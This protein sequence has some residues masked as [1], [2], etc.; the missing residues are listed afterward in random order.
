MKLKSTVKKLLKIRQYISQSHYL[1]YLE[2]LAIDESA[3]LLECQHGTAM[4]GNI[5]YLLKEL[6][7]EEK[8]SHFKV[9]ISVNKKYKKDIMAILNSYSFDRYNVVIMNTDEY[10]QKI[11][12]CKYL[13]NDNTFLP[14]FIKRKE[15]V[16]LNT[17]H[18]TPLKTLGKKINND[19]HNI[20]NTMKNFI[21]SDYLLYPNEH[22]KDVMIEDYMLENLSQ[23]KVVL[24]GYPRNSIFFD[25]NSA[26][27]VRKKYN[28]TDK[29]VIAYMPTWRGTT[30][31]KNVDEQI[32]EILLYLHQIDCQLDEDCVIYV[33]FHPI[34]HAQVKFSQF[35][36]IKSFPSNIDT[37]EF[38]NVCDVLITDYSSVFFDYAISRKK[39]ILFTYDKEQYFEDRGV[40]IS[41]D[42]LPFPKVETVDA[43]MAEIKKVKNYDDD[44]FIKEFC[45][46]ENI[47]SSGKLLDLVL[48]GENHSLLISDI[49]NNGKENVLIY[50]GN[51]AK[52]GITSSLMN[53]L[54]NIDLDKRN[55]YVTFFSRRVYPYRDTIRMLPKQ[56]GFIPVTGKMNASLAEKQILKKYRA[57]KI[58]IDE[59]YPTLKKLY[60]YEILRKFGTDNFNHVIHFTG[61]EF[62]MQLLFSF[63]EKARKSIFVHSNMVEE[64]RV[65]KNQHL[66][67]LKYAYT[68]Y[69][70]V[71]IIT[72]DMFAPTKEI[73]G[74]DK[75][76]YVVSNTFDYRN[77]I[78]KSK[79]EIAFDENTKC[80]ITEQELK[81]IMND[82]H[83]IKFINIGRFS[84]E[85]GHKRLILAFD[86]IYNKHS[87][88]YLIIIGGHGV[89]YENTIEM[90]N[91]LKSKTH[92]ILIKS[93][94]NPFSILKKCQCFAFSSFYEGLGLVVLEADVLGVSVFSTNIPG[95]R[96]FI[97]KYGGVLVDNSQ[98]GLEEGFEKYYQG[99][100]HPMGI[101]Y[102]K[103]NA[104]AVEEFENLLS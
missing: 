15:Q 29:K 89:E 42:D 92:I 67:T 97:T 28:L 77:V 33:N 39:I 22:T 86:Q 24:G 96:G 3:I 104:E 31:N 78:E 47:N 48:F 90:I 37:Y 93:M 57:D 85:K 99:Q 75:N 13:I 53:L 30:A 11:A 12:T 74:S 4:N 54:Q 65:R 69:D 16:Y 45:S 102:D 73:A 103:Y 62:K 76:F 68:H 34:I 63:F 58:S 25:K 43:L 6:C 55:Y 35:Q 59:T 32:E 2:S 88:A 36:K 61:Y 41:I 18:G 71:A 66:N 7:T 101:D 64:L 72:K 94:S 46:Y 81:E 8:Y 38:L 79:Q 23:A 17:W 84:P 21:V 83:K 9:Y 98:F 10:Y 52:N 87:D 51:F 100:I 95:P 19:F 14:F 44:D 26:Q 1:H 60:S 27:N 82:D 56:V 70:R 20:G 80:N 91:T 5:F 49:P 50:G 40:Y